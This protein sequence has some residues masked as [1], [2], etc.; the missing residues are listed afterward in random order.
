MFTFTKM[1]NTT[2]IIIILTILTLISC[3]HNRK[4]SET[5]NDRLELVPE[6][7]KDL[8]EKYGQKKDSLKISTNKKIECNRFS[9]A[10][11]ELKELLEKENYSVEIREQE[12]DLWFKTE[13]KNN[14]FEVDKNISFPKSQFLSIY[15]KRKN[16]LEH[17]QGNWFPS[18]AVIEI[19][20]QDERTASKSHQ[21]I[22]EI[23]N[24]RDL[25]NEKKYDYILENG[26]SLIYV[27]CKAKIFEEYALSYKDKIE[28]IIK[29]NK[30]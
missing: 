24:K 2:H 21:K 9:K 19:C 20:F 15:A 17:M 26:N 5:K 12:N 8:K 14:K 18:F 3:N 28:E 6:P 11:S 25:Y 22:S 29:K 10:M 16:K 1:K 13:S 4:K 23:I 27:S 7:D 30:R